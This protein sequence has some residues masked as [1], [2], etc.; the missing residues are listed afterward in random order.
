MSYL[1]TF[2]FFP[3]LP[4][5]LDHLGI[6]IKLNIYDNDSLCVLNSYVHGGRVEMN[7]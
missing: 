3:G 6:G 5:S 4:V 2:F 1:I 7:N